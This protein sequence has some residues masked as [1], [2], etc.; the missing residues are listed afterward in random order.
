MAIAFS[1]RA[2][3]ATAFLFDAV[4]ELERVGAPRLERAWMLQT[5]AATAAMGGDV[6]RARSAAEAALPLARAVGNPSEL[7]AALWSIGITS[8]IDDPARA[9]AAAEESIAIARNGASGAALGHTLA[10]R[11]QLRAQA[12]D[13]RSALVDLRDSLSYSYDKGDRVMLM[14]GF[15]RG[16]TVLAIADDLEGASTL[17]GVAN[18]SALA[19]LTI[20]SRPEREVRAVLAEE[21]REKLG[22][23]AYEEAVATGAAMTADQ[24]TAEVLAGSAGSQKV[25][26]ASP[27]DDPD[28]TSDDCLLP[29][30][31]NVERR[32][33]DDCVRWCR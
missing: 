18:Q 19:P 26:P 9:T 23:A 28:Q 4:A 7:A 16:V 31:G 24:A 12:G 5:I 20:L 33:E 15:D 1:G 14:V 21:L 8:A 3:E 17:L 6:E 13:V 27:S 30:E 29:F 11:A 25:W 2:E 32:A 22:D 10:L